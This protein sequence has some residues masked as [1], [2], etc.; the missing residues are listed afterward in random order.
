[1]KNVPANCIHEPWIISEQIQ[2]KFKVKIVDQIGLILSSTT[3]SE[4]VCHY[5]S[6]FYLKPIVN[7]ISSAKVAKEQMSAVRKK[8]STKVQA[9]K[10]FVKHGKRRNQTNNAN[11]KN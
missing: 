9:M 6:V 2:K 7:K 10:V 4:N 3:S 8:T 1:M 11:G 5:E